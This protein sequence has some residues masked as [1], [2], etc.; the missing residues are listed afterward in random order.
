MITEKAKVR[1]V[2]GC[3]SKLIIQEFGKLV[4]IDEYDGKHGK[5]RNGPIRSGTPNQKPTLLPPIRSGFALAIIDQLHRIRQKEGNR[6][7]GGRQ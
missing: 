6:E 7:E 3:A 1:A 2:T 5:D 4:Q